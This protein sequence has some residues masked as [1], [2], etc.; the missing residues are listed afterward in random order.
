MKARACLFVLSLAPLIG[1]AQD[2]SGRYTPNSQPK[3][4]AWDVVSVKQA[5]AQKC[6]GMGMG[7]TADGI[8]ISCVPLVFLIQ[9]T[10]GIPEV[11]RI[12]GAPEWAKDSLRYEIHAKVAGEDAAAFDRLG[13]QEMKR[14]LHYCWQ[15][16]SA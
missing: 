13:Q 15:T 9:E 2:K 4:P 14:M 12:V 16:A 8:D 1:P 3:L 5:D 6:Q 10:Y 11:N 7:K